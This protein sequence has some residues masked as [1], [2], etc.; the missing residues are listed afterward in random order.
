MAQV[1]SKGR[2]RSVRWDKSSKKIYLEDH[3]FFK[4]MVDIGI[5]ADSEVQAIVIAKEYL[6]LHPSF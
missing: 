4:N 2:T 1:V 5:K 3:R 6:D